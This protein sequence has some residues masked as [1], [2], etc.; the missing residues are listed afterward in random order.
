MDCEKKKINRFLVERLKT[1]AGA[2]ELCGS[3]RNLDVHHIIPVVYGGTDE[4]D[5]LIVVCKHC[6]GAL[7]PQRTLT[8]KGI[9]DQQKRNQ[10]VNLMVWYYEQIDPDNWDVDNWF[11]LADAFFDRL[12]ET[13]WPWLGRK[14]VK[15]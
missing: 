8:R 9:E 2:C 3:R 7:T 13:V 14:Y 4:E 11:D 6:H 10:I 5:N 15:Q 1:Q 12:C